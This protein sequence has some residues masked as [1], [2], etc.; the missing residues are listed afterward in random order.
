[1]LEPGGLRSAIMAGIRLPRDREES[2]ARLR[3]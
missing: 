2:D 3:T 1:M